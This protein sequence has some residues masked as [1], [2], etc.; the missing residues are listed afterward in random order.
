MGFSNETAGIN[1]LHLI[2]GSDSGLL[3]LQDILSDA[4]LTTIVI[5]PTQSLK[6][7]LG[8]LEHLKPSSGFDAIH[9]YG[10]GQPGEQQL[11]RAFQSK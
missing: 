8:E 3:G 5:G 9:L 1:T 2:D 6:D 10:H 4:G 7:V 11:G